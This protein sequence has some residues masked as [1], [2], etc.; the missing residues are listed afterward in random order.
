M[1]KTTLAL[2]L[3]LAANGAAGA[4]FPGVDLTGSISTSISAPVPCET[5]SDVAV[6]RSAGILIRNTIGVAYRGLRWGDQSLQSTSKMSSDLVTLDLYLPTHSRLRPFV[7]AGAGHSSANVRVSD[8]G[9]AYYSYG[10]AGSLYTRFWGFGVDIRIYRRLAFSPMVSSTSTGESASA[11]HCT[12]YN[13]MS[14]DFSV[15]CGASGS[16]Q[17][18]VRGVSVG[19]GIR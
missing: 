18:A 3:L 16:Q 10:P 6:H 15:T 4:Q 14:G 17:F 12:A 11:Q 1:R 5:C 19:F 2:L 8:G 13:Y 7:S 9:H